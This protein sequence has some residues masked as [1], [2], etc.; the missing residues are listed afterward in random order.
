MVTWG[1]G[2][3]SLS[4][5]LNMIHITFEGYFSSTNAVRGLLHWH[6]T[7]LSQLGQATCWTLK[8]GSKEAQQNLERPQWP[9]GLTRL[10][11]PEGLACVGANHQ[12]EAGAVLLLGHSVERRSL[13]FVTEWSTKLNSTSRTLRD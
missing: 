13:I 9:A 5:L 12:R 11:V 3:A 1:R 2:Y 8:F 7:G 4:S 10:K 6:R